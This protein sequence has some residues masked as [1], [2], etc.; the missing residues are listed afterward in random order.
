MNL[1]PD[2]YHLHDLLTNK[3]AGFVQKQALKVLEINYL[4]LANFTDKLTENCVPT[5]YCWISASSS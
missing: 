5:L 4:L 1:L 3:K 2:C